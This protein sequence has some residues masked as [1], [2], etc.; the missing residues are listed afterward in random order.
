MLNT[1]QQKY[2]SDQ[3]G[4]IANILF[5]TL[6]ISNFLPNNHFNLKIF[7]ISLGIVLAVYTAG[8]MFRRNLNA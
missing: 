2:I 3:L 7:L 5:G 8:I 4:T 1:S 6:F